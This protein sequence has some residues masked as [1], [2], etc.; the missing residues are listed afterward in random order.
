MGIKTIMDS[1]KIILLANGEGKKDAI[2]NTVKGKIDP[3]VPAS[4]LQLHKDVTLIID[5]KAAS[6]LF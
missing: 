2:Y 4:I 1:K 3:Q 6:R 5:E